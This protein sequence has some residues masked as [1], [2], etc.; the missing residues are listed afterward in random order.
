MFRHVFFIATLLFNL[1]YKTGDAKT[2]L[3]GSFKTEAGDPDASPGVGLAVA[4]CYLLIRKFKCRVH[5]V[6]TDAIGCTGS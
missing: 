4:R 6:S 1:N 3:K 2:A 5:V